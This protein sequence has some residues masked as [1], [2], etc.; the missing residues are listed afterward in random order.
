MS[1]VENYY[2]QNAQDEWER[3]ER[4][5]IVFQ[6]TMRALSEFLP[7][8]CLRPFAVYRAERRLMLSAL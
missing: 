7:A 2:D 3:L 5:R 8:G 1:N 6:V 4:H